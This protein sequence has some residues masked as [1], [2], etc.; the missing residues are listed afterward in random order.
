MSRELSKEAIL[1]VAVRQLED[2][3]DG[4]PGL[5]LTGI[6]AELGV[7]QPALYYHVSGL[8]GIWRELGLRKRR[9]LAER[10]EAA[11][12]NMVGAGAV[13]SVATAWRG[14]AHDN[15]ALYI[16]G[17]RSVVSGDADL[18]AA[19]DRVLRAIYASLLDS[20]LDDDTRMCAAIALRGLLHGFCLFELR[21]GNPSSL[22]SD[23]QFTN[24]VNLFLIGVRSAAAGERQPSGVDPESGRSGE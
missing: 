3:D 10:L 18:E 5:T 9:E 4:C 13:M 15:V 23:E 12:V 21:E 22:R 1:D 2:L 16:A 14:F 17:S 7:T 8:D 19:V 20:G 24:A 6:A 11:C